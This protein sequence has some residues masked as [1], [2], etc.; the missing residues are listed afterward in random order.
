MY[1]ITRQGDTDQYNLMSYMCDNLA[2]IETLPTDCSAGST[3]IV[4]EDSSVWMLGT[5]KTW[6]E[7]K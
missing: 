7:L 3:C 5:D 4:I 2:D 6:K 1:N